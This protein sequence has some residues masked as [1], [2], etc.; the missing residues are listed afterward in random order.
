MLCEIVRK[1]RSRQY[2]IVALEGTGIA[3]G[4][5][6]IF[7]RVTAGVP[8]IVS[9]GDAVAPFLRRVWPWSAPFAGAYERSLYSLSA[10][11]IGWT[12]YLVGRALT[13]GARRAITVPGWA[14]FLRTR[15]QL[16][17]A[18]R[19][20]RSKL[21]IPADTIVFGIVGSLTW[22]N[23][24]QY[25]YGLELVRAIAQ[26]RRDDVVALIVGDGTAVLRLRE[27]AGDRIGKSVFMAGRVPQ[28]AV[29]DYL[30]AMDVG[31]LPQSVDGVGNFRYT[32]KLSEYVSVG[33][34][35]VTGQTPL[36]YEFADDWLWRLTG[37]AP[38]S[39]QYV[40][41][42]AQLMETVTREEI[43]E[44]R[45][46]VG[47]LSYL[48]D[49]KAAG[50]PRHV[51]HQRVVREFGSNGG[52][53]KR[54]AVLRVAILADFA[55]ERWP[56]MDLVAEMLQTHL[57]IDYRA[58]IQATLV[59]PS[60]IRIFGRVANRN[61]AALNAD[62]IFN[63]FVRYPLWLRAHRDG[64]DLFHVADHSYSQLVHRLPADR[65]IV[66]CHDLDTFRCILEPPTEQRSA[67]FS[68][69]G[70]VHPARSSTRC[71]RDLRQRG[72]AAGVDSESA[73]SRKQDLRDSVRRTSR[74]Q[75]AD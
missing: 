36:A 8:Y 73:S 17:V 49:Q 21:R 60:F 58:S 13:L 32:T 41:A 52:A 42:L 16:E 70:S 10:G 54:M 33:L 7:G 1:I 26:V 39:S 27:L 65:T 45:S 2:D 37:D 9:T 24:V 34:P 12:P 53:L 67:A 29:P 5:A 35:V 4:L 18:R 22:T 15:E 68:S 66:S 38:W 61:A 6:V 48:F 43:A 44:K 57:S 72:D 71:A 46:C 31:S 51:V 19:E 14:P 28:S 59:R 55:E 11:V 3:G 75:C 62:R 47:R 74:I 20:I 63:R 23:R 40:G 56:S 64:F 30:A 69:D 25:S 50:Q